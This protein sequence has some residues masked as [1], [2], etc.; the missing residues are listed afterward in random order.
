MKGLPF[1]TTTDLFLVKNRTA[2]A[3]RFYYEMSRG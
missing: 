1:E 3:V 2:L